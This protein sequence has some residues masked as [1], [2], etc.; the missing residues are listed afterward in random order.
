MAE[1]SGL[2]CV[3]GENE[4]GFKG[5]G[6]DVSPEAWD[7]ILAGGGLYD[8]LDYS[9]TVSNPDGTRSATAPGGGSELCNV[10]YECCTNSSTASTSCT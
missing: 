6:D 5:S 2:S 10:N 7:F 4:T 8:N 1:N 3:I 9:F